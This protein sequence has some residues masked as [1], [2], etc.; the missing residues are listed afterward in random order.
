ELLAG[1]ADSSGY[2]E[3]PMTPSRVPGVDGDSPQ[4]TWGSIDGTPMI[5]DPRAT[6]L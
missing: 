6:P 4:I 5:L 2:E 1:T 3:V